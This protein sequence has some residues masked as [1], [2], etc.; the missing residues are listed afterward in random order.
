MFD[1][2]LEGWLKTGKEENPETGQHQ[3]Q[4]NHL[5]QDGGGNAEV[6]NRPQ[7]DSRN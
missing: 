2:C 1:E 5:Q 3:R 4:T 7:T 6:T